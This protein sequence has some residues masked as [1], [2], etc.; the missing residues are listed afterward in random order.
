M[1][2]VFQEMFFKMLTLKKM[3]F[4]FK[5]GEMMRAGILAFQ[6][7]RQENWS[8][9]S[10]LATCKTLSQKTFKKRKNNVVFIK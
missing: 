3:Y 5:L 1:A 9:K 8:L 4:S 2:D 10:A 6:K 7:A